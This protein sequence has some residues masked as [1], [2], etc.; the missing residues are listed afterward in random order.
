M[1]I[2]YIDNI[3][4]MSLRFGI[5]RKQRAVARKI[6]HR[7]AVNTSRPTVVIDR[8]PIGTVLPFA[9]VKPPYNYLICDGSEVNRT[10]YRELFTIIGTRFGSGD[11]SSTFNLPDLRLRF[12]IGATGSNIYS[13]CGST[14]GSS[15]K[16]IEISHMPSHSHTGIV[17]ASGTHN[18]DITIDNGGLHNHDQVTRN[19][20]FNNSGG[21]TSAG[22][23]GYI[24][25][26]GISS[27][28]PSYPQSDSAG[29][30]TW[31]S[32]IQSDGLHS[33]T[34]SIGNNGEHTHNFTT[35]LTGG[36]S[37]LNVMNPYVS[38]VYIIKCKN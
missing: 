29:S 10:K 19:D 8:V 18:H 27:T 6:P 21:G 16:I 5:E 2:I 37:P 34:A 17:D 9:S 30:V 24:I 1:N 38:L 25:T 12:P 4:N 22:A 13:N 15:T 35:Q 11:N 33:H 14:G 20:D 31:P 23:E 36:G 26:N 28:L 7:T 3:D 32:T